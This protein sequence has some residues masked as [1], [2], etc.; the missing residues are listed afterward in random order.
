VPVPTRTV[1]E[2]EIVKVW[3]EETPVVVFKLATSWT[4]AV[5]LPLASRERAPAEANN[6]V[7]LAPVSEKA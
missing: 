3:L 1:E 5:A 6:P 7:A 2:V 4:P